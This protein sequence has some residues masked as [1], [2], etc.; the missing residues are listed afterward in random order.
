MPPCRQL[1]ELDASRH[2]KEGDSHGTQLTVEGRE[3]KDGKN[4]EKA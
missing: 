1:G 2:A 4:A 3:R